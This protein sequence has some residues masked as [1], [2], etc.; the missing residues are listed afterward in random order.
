[1]VI[2]GRLDE[3]IILKQ[4]TKRRQKW[5]YQRLH[6]TGPVSEDDK[7]WY[8]V[9]MALCIHLFRRVWRTGCRSNAFETFIFI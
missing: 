8:Q 5:A 7:A 2:A 1:M 3:P 6:L 4:Y 9:I